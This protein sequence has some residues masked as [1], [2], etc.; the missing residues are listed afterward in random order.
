MYLNEVQGII[1]WRW[2]LQEE[3]IP[4]KTPIPFNGE[5][6]EKEPTATPK[7]L[8]LLPP[9]FVDAAAIVILSSG[10]IGVRL[11]P[12]DEPSSPSSCNIYHAVFLYPN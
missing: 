3:D 2:L 11:L 6:T 7:L 9:S 5:W 1:D 4:G 8:S 10:F 12:H